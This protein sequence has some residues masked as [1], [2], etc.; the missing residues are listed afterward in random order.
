VR[1]VW[2]YAPE[3][4]GKGGGRTRWTDGESAWLYDSEKCRVSRAGGRG[5]GRGVTQ[6][7]LAARS[8][9]IEMKTGLARVD[10][11]GCK[12]TGAPGWSTAVSGSRRQTRSREVQHS[13]PGVNKDTVLV[14]IGAK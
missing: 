3:T 4:D 8:T 14:C 10:A 12:E 5:G 1:T 13:R 9:P 2:R 7:D 6:A 11:L